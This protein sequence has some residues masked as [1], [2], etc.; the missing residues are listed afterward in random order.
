MTDD[1]EVRVR[2]QR[3]RETMPYL[4]TKIEEVSR[5]LDMIAANGGY[6]DCLFRIAAPM[7]VVDVSGK[8]TEELESILGICN[9]EL[10]DSRNPYARYAESVSKMNTDSA[11]S[12]AAELAARKAADAERSAR[13]M[14][15]IENL[16]EIVEGLMRHA[17]AQGEKDIEKKASESE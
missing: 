7:Q 14:E 6:F 8:E 4:C 15:I 12:L 13:R 1:V 5:E 9:A 2:R 17:D 3:K 11:A 16:P 10:K